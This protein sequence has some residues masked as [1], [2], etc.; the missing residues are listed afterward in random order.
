MRERPTGELGTGDLEAFRRAGHALVDAVA[1][2]LAA[3]PG[4]PVWEPLPDGL[5]TELLS[6]P[7]PDG[8]TALGP[9][10]AT[11][12]RDVLPHARGAG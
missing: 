2:H 3:L 7:L 12:A 10:T 8:P 4:Q 5:R 9:L 11:M 6:L 1:D